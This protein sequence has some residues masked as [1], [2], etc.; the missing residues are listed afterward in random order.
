MSY[1]VPQV[2]VRMRVNFEIVIMHLFVSALLWFVH[3]SVSL[4][5]QQPSILGVDQSRIEIGEETL[6]EW[7]NKAFHSPCWSEAVRRLDHSCKQLSDVEQ[8]RLA[9]AFANCHLD[10]SGRQTYPCTEEMSIRECTGTMDHDGYQTY[11]HFFT[12]TGH[13]CYFLQIELWQGRTEG[14]IGRLS[15]TSIQAVEK[16]ERSLEY[17]RVMDDKQSTAL[18]NQDLILQQD[19]KIITSL[20]QTHTDMEASFHEMSA[21][22]ESQKAL[23]GEMFGSLQSSLE[24]VRGVMSLMVVEFIGWETL[25][26]FVV[27]MGGCDVP[28]SVPLQQVQAGGGTLGRGDGGGVCQEDVWL[29]GDGRG[30]STH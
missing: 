4:S 23:L 2:R 24:A 7:E 25:V 5:Q 29:P 20:Q 8:S 18:H 16:L 28:A 3:G 10:K 19:Q 21:M 9:V 27:V 30:D 15:A 22:A 12:H 1:Y 11:T 14:L 13:I 26:L 17:H 6:R